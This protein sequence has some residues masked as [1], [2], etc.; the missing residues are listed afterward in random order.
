MLTSAAENAV[1]E[2]NMVLREDNA[3]VTFA[4]L[5]KHRRLLEFPPL[6]GR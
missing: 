3:D 2:I 4:L 6:A 5:K 1:I